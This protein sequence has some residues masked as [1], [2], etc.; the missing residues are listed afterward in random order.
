MDAEWDVLELVQAVCDGDAG[1]DH[2]DGV[3][4]HVGVGQHQDVQEVEKTP[5]KTNVQGKVAVYR[6]VHSLLNKENSLM[7]K[8][9]NV[10]KMKSSILLLPAVSSY[11]KPNLYICK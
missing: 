3:V 9:P 10:I 11:S 4:P 5:Q 7:K 6:R 8:C 2:V 1:E